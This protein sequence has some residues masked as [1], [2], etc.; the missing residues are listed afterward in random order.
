MNSTYSGDNY[1]GH[2]HHEAKAAQNTT[3]IGRSINDLAYVL[4]EQ[5]DIVKKLRDRLSRVLSPIT[6]APECGVSSGETKSPLRNDVDGQAARIRDTNAA[7]NELLDR[8]EI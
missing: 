8:L 6:P 3:P 7:L 5:D 1:P 4:N 2:P